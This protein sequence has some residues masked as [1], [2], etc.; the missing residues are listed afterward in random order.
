MIKDEFKVKEN[1]KEIDIITL[2]LIKSGGFDYGNKN[3]LVLTSKE[4]KTE[5]LFDV[6]Y[7]SRFDNEETFHKYSY[8]FV[9]DYVRK[10]LEIEKNKM[11][12][13]NKE[14][15]ANVIKFK[16]IGLGAKFIRVKENE[17]YL[18]TKI[19]NGSINAIKMYDGYTY[20]INEE[21]NV[22][23]VIE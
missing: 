2:E 22:I 16:D 1:G 6:R 15:I 9:R 5:N 10:D 7:D 20:K 19:N 3:A 8:E 13:M 14:I 4:Y 11:K 17:K 12:I 18:Y 23:L 21:E